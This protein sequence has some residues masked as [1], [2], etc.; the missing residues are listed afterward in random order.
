[1]RLVAAS[2]VVYAHSFTV[3]GHH[4]PTIFGASLG[5]FGVSIFF[6]TS[7][8][9]I[10]ASWRADPR[11]WVF[12]RKR[13][14]RILPA[15]VPLA[16]ALVVIAQSGLFDGNPRH[17]LDPPLWTLPVEARCYLLVAILGLVA[18]GRPRLVAPL[19]GVLV[20]VFI[21]TRRPDMVRIVE[22]LGRALTSKP[23]EFRF[24]AMLYLASFL[25]GMLM[26]Y[27][28]RRRSL[29]VVALLLLLAEPGYFA[30]VLAIPYLVVFVAESSTFSLKHDVSYGLYIWGWPA[31]QTIVALGVVA[32][33]AIFPAALAAAG[34]VALGSW[35]AVERPALRLKG[36]RAVPRHV[37]PPIRSTAAST[38]A[39]VAAVNL[40]D[41]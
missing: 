19:Y 15:L 40:G 9:L 33:L 4:E 7:G 22:D 13:C 2:L 23:H 36:R 39:A 16:L 37:A 34:A 32:P 17:E 41:S 18:A 31:Q 27:V 14:L 10:A 12:A 11:F 35:L 24:T 28:P 38:T 21:A 8:Y 3:V 30:W 29:A 20:V 5:A 1:M 25:G 26:H 6:A